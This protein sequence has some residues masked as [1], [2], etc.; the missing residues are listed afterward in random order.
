VQITAVYQ[1]MLK[2]WTSLY[3]IYATVYIHVPRTFYAY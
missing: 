3:C 2:A 1:M